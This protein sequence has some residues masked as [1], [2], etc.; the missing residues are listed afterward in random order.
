[1]NLDV[2]LRPL[3]LHELPGLTAAAA[4]DQ[5]HIVIHPT[6]GVWRGGESVG[7][8]SLGAVKLFFAWLDTQ[9][10]SAHESFNAWRQAELVLRE[11]HAGPV[12]LPCTAGS[13]LLPFVE[14]MGYR[15]LGTA[16][17][18]LKDF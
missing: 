4:A 7:Y 13:P 9:K 3:R 16:H 10:L 1:M 14:R 15:R 17:F 6:H 11:Q 18:H 8:A 12:C 2:T 5:G